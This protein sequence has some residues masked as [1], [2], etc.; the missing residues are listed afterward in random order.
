MSPKES[1]SYSV[2]LGEKGRIVVPSEV[3]EELGLTTGERLQ[4][5][6]DADG[7]L[8]LISARRAAARLKGLFAHLTRGRSLADELVEER[9]RAAEAEER[10]ADRD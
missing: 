5:V 1:A 4:L 10:N 2:L 9:R 7:S 3:R 6:V 8:R